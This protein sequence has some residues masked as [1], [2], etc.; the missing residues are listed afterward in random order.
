MTVLFTR[1]MKEVMAIFQQ[2]D[3]SELNRHAEEPEHESDL[4]GNIIWEP[5]N[6]GI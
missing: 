6:A 2:L 3:I 1:N 4:K 5:Q